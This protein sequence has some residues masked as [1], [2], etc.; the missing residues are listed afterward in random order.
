M[1]VGGWVDRYVGRPKL[2][3]SLV[4]SYLDQL[5]SIGCPI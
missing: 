2:L 3:S 4:N 1:M 5:G